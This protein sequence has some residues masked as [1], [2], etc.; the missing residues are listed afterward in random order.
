MKTLSK[1][2]RHEAFW[3]NRIPG[4]GSGKCKGSGARWYA[5]GLNYN[6]LAIVA[7][8]GKASGKVR[9]WDQT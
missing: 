7:E 8:A 9:S 3:R 2:R 4:Q 6:T 5:A 1:Q